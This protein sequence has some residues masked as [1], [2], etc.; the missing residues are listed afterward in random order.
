M[1][2]RWLTPEFA[3]AHPDLRDGLRDMLA[4]SPPD[5]Y[6][7]ACGALERM[8][9]RPI[10]AD[11]QAPTL[12]IGGARDLAAP[13]DD[14][15]RVIAEGIPGARLELVDGAHVANVEQPERVTELILD[16]LEAS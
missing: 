16:H 9:L 8:D 11:V 15:A 14:H 5:G 10:L 6:V 12:V 3:A 1:S 4:A 7:A 2:E 13:P